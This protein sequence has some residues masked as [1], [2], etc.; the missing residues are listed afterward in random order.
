MFKLF[1][2]KNISLKD[3]IDKLAELGITLNSGVELIDLLEEN[4]EQS[5][6]SEPFDLLLLT[7]G[8]E[9]FKEAIGGRNKNYIE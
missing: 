7:L 5:Y 4:S 1:R 6:E 2:K 9:I 8:G 3:Q